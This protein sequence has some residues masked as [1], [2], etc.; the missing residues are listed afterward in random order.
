MPQLIHLRR[1]TRNHPLSNL[2]H[3]TKN[4]R[5]PADSVLR[6]LSRD[7]DDTDTWVLGTTVVLAVAEVTE[8]SFEGWGVVFADAL[9]VG[10]DFGAAA[11]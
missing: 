5:T 6:S 1:L 3:A 11:D 10:L 2:Q 7:L 9:A 4:G 8:P